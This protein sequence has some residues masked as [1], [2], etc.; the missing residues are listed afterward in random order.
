M[1]FSISATIT[2]IAACQCSFSTALPFGSPGSESSARRGKGPRMPYKVVPIDGGDGSLSSEAPAPTSTSGAGTGSGSGSH[3]GSGSG[4]GSGSMSISPTA[5][6]DRGL[7]T[8]TQ[9]VIQTLPPTTQT[10]FRTSTPTTVISVVDVEFTAPPPPSTMTTTIVRYMPPSSISSAPGSS[11]VTPQPFPSSFSSEPWYT[12]TIT[13]T[14]ALTTS[15][16]STKTYD[17][18]MWHTTYPPWNGTFAARY[19]RRQ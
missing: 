11:A 13:S 3:P 7:V 2:L 6:P 18:G 17:D 10:V 14:A 9:T 8:V 4:T 16:T 12:P 5:G 1:R 15:A 19:G